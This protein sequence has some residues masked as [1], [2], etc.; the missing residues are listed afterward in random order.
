LASWA[1]NRPDWPDR[2]KE[3]VRLR[4][5][6]GPNREDPCT[7]IAEWRRAVRLTDR[8]AGLQDELCAGA[9]SGSRLD[10]LIGDGFLPLLAAEADLDLQ[11]AWAGWLAGDAPAAVVRV[12]RALGVF[13]GHACPIAQGPIQGLL[14]W[15]LAREGQLQ[16]K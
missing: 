10:N 1:S 14:G 2:L 3:N 16:G 8:R 12:L 5:L 13:D 4:E 6:A 9:L 11:V 15:M 7:T